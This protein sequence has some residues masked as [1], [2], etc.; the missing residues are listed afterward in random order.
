MALKILLHKTDHLGDFVTAL[1]VLW[2]LRQSLGQEADV[3]IL[4]GGVNCEWSSLLPWLGV[5]HPVRHP[6]YHRGIPRSK[7]AMTWAALKQALA[8]RSHRFDW[9]IDLVS[10][11]NDLL[12]KWLLRAA[13][14]RRICGPD[15]AHSWLLNHRFPEPE[16]HQTRILA[17]RF[18]SEWKLEG[19]ALPEQW[20]PQN[21]RW[22]PGSGPVF[23]APFV[24]TPAKR[25]PE[26]RWL[27]L[28]DKI[29]QS[30]PVQFLVPQPDLRRNQEFLKQLPDEEIRVVSSIRETLE[31][32]RDSRILVCLDTAVAHFA[33]ATGTPY[34]Q[35]FSGTTR[36][37]RWAPPGA[38]VT[39][40]NKPSCYPCSSETCLA[41]RHFCMEEFEVDEVL[42]KIRE[43]MK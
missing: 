43:F 25:W 13:G 26:S 23:L 14:C 15:G 17:A 16:A 37:R 1:P 7:T 30:H 9:G 8:L 32:L 22:Q 10:T 2:E 24:G 28:A 27:E 38:G 34:A 42:E 4:A 39:L 35:L 3:H 20:M 21:F 6:R 41:E 19:K 33:W 40:Q 29:R 5:M 18:P 31:C 36:A 12:G 11:R